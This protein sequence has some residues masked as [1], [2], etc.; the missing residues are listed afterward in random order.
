MEDDMKMIPVNAAIMLPSIVLSIYVLPYLYG[1][2]FLVPFVILSLLPIVKKLAPQPYSFYVYPVAA[3]SVLLIILLNLLVATG[4]VHKSIFTNFFHIPLEIQTA[5]TLTMALSIAAVLEG[6]FSRTL[7]RSIGYMTF[8]LLPLLDQVFVLY[9]MQQFG[10]GYIT[11]YEQAYSQQIFSM[12]AL[13]FTGSVNIMGH[14]YPPPLSEYNF[15]IDN[16]MLVA[17]IISLAAI[18]FY[19]VVIRE[20]K[21]RNE[22]LGGVAYSLLLGGMIGFVVFY[23]VQITTPSG[24]ELFAA[25][26]S[27]VI[28]LVYAATTSPERR[29]RKKNGAKARNDW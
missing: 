6:I 11:A 21:L 22:V 12:L 18:M 4:L 24:F 3:I 2:I 5:I 13:I 25:A 19:F 20:T 23:I 9:L 26:L 8:S 27:L 15:P 1:V 29:A 28:T 17:M 16:V 10:F 14:K 7:S